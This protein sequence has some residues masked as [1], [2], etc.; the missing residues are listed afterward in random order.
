MISMITDL[1]FGVRGDSRTW[2][3][4]MREFYTDTY[5]P[6]ILRDEIK[7]VVILGDVFDKR[8]SV[9]VETAAFAREVLFDPLEQIGVHV[10]V[11]CGNHD[12]ALRN[13]NRFNSLE[14]L[15]SGRRNVTIYTEP[16][17]TTLPGIGKVLMLPWINRENHQQCLHH[18]KTTS[19]GVVFSHLEL[20]GFEYHVGQVSDHGHIDAELLDR[21]RA[22]YTGHYHHKSSKGNIHYLGTPYQLTW[23]DYADPKGFHII[24]ADGSLEFIKNEVETFIKVVYDDVDNLDSVKKF[25]NLEESEEF[26]NRYVEVI[27][28]RKDNPKT[29]ERFLSKVNDMLPVECVVRDQTNRLVEAKED[30]VFSSDALSFSMQYVDEMVETDLSKDTIKRKIAALYS[31]ANG[32]EMVD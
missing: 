9:G 15:Y 6:R 24:K 13:T 16:T 18:L 1:H 4:I 31:R 23:A 26:K 30:V 27:V 20:A 10:H 2:H 21:F 28:K 17:E 5:I 19:A 32:M 3:D 14:M 22:V 25:L 7:T 12:V 11:I 29:F 8:K